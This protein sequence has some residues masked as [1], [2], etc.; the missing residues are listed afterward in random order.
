LEQRDFPRLKLGIGR[1]LYGEPIESFV[2]QPPYLEDQHLF[3]GMVRLSAEAVRTVLRSG[4]IVAMNH[5]NR[6]E[7]TSDGASSSGGSHSL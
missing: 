6:R 2:L 1:P 4:L 7:P 3:Q 5:Y